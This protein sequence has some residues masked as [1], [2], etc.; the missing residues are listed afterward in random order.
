MD[1]FD[2]RKIIHKTHHFLQVF[3]PQRFNQGLKPGHQQEKK[4]QREGVGFDKSPQE[5]VG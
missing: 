3:L 5:G 2:Y 1:R 4:G